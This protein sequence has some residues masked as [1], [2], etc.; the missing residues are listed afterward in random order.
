MNLAHLVGRVPDLEVCLILELLSILPDLFGSELAYAGQHT[1]GKQI[2][3]DRLVI[4]FACRA[5]WTGGDSET[6]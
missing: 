5:V 3:L 4:S 6:H 1:R 2:G